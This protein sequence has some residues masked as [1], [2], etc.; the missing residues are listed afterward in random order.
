ESDI[1]LLESGRV[2]GAVSSDGDD[3]TILGQRGVDDSLDEVVLV[4]RLRSSKHSQSRPYLVEFGLVD[5]SLLI[6]D[7][8]VELA[9]LKCEEI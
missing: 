2:I 1:G 9:A 8:R 3:L 6:S 5:Q 7:S 4:C